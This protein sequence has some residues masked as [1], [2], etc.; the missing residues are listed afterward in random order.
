M[1]TDKWTLAKKFR[2]PMIQLTNHVK[3]KKKEGPIEN[4]LIPFKTGIKITIEI[5]REGPK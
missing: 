2:I 1:L 3:L 4:A 5:R